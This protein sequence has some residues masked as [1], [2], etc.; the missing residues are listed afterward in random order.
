MKKVLL[1]ALTSLSILTGAVLAN[2]KDRNWRDIDRADEHVRKAIEILNRANNDNR[3][4][5]KGEAEDALHL[6]RRARSKLSDAIDNVKKG[7]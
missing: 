2:D 4:D 5:K 7:K 3:L 1:I 6:L